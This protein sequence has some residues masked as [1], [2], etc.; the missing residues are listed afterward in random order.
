M[1][2]YTEN[3]KYMFRNAETFNSRVF[4]KL[5]PFVKLLL[6]EL[7]EINSDSLRKLLVSC[8]TDQEILRTANLYFLIL[9]GILGLKSYYS[10]QVSLA[11][12]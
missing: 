1:T 2:K 12:N 6:G 10:Y 9:P 4:P 7:M 3:S 11:K 8:S 5:P